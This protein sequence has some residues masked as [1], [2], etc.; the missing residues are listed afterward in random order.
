MVTHLANPL[1]CPAECSGMARPIIQ[2]ICKPDKNSLIK[3]NV[4]EHHNYLHLVALC[5]SL[6]FSLISRSGFERVNQEDAL[7][8]KRRENNFPLPPIQMTYKYAEMP[9]IG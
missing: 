9:M 4:T 1:R 8:I 7:Q 3:I 5:F 6:A 2:R